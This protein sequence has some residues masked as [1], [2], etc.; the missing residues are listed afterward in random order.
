MELLELFGTTGLVVGVCMVGV[1]ILSLFLRDASIADVFWGMGFVLIAAV[2]FVWTDEGDAGRRGLMLVMVSLWGL[3][4]AGYLLWRNSEVGE[5]PRYAAMRRRWGWRFWPVS[6]VTVF[7]FQ[8]VLMWVVSLPLQVALAAPGGPLGTLDMIGVGI[9]GLGL[10]FEAV[11][12][13][14][15]ARFK[16]DPESAGRVMD[17]GLWRYTRHPNY[18]GDCC[19]WWGIWVVALSTPYGIWTVVGPALMSFLLLRVSGVPMLERS[20]HKR[21]PDY[22]EYVK[23]TSSFFPLPPKRAG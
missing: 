4:L 2:S 23:R 5:D 7:L 15:L 13:R 14:Q 17:R 8:G 19:V 18:F 16:G 9:W 12:D 22:A 20:I 6:L 11:A 3:R 10:L 1:W 21:R